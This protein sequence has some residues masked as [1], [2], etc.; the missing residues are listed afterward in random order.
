M[1]LDRQCEERV[2]AAFDGCGRRPRHQQE[3]GVGLE[4]AHAG[5][6]FGEV[7]IE[8]LAPRIAR[9]VMRH[10]CEESAA[11]D[12]HADRPWLVAMDE[13]ADMRAGADQEHALRG[14][15]PGRARE[16]GDA[17]HQQSQREQHRQRRQI[18]QHDP[19]ARIDHRNLQQEAERQQE[20]RGYVP[21]LHGAAQ[22][23]L[24]AEIVLQPIFAAEHVRGDEDARR[25]HADLDEGGNVADLAVGGEVVADAGEAGHHEDQRDVDEDNAAGKRAVRQQRP[26]VQKSP[27]LGAGRQR[28]TQMRVHARTAGTR[29]R[30]PPRNGTASAV[31]S[32]PRE[33]HA[34]GG[35][36]CG[37]GRRTC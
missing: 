25:Q 9:S 15:Q 34:S 23:R 31:P 8:R 17:H 6:R 21:Q 1:N 33:K 28:V 36:D 11:D 14:D 18:E 3:D 24:E 26:A 30:A 13:G 4:A 27:C 22:M 12:V 29:C 20:H 16:R 2:R 5:D 7:M 19:A 35:G 32:L 37:G 10:R